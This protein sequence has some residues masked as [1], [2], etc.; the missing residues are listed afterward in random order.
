MKSGDVCWWLTIRQHL[1][2]WSQRIKICV[3]H[4]S[5][6]RH[7]LRHVILK[8]TSLITAHRA[9]FPTNIQPEGQHKFAIPGIVDCNYLTRYRM[10]VTGKMR[11]CG[12]RKVKCGIENAEAHLMAKASNHMTA[13]IPHITSIYCNDIRTVFDST[14]YFPH[15]AIP[16]LPI[17]QDDIYCNCKNTTPVFFWLMTNSPSLA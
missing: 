15:S 9:T 8:T 7:S 12:M 5:F 13:V 6:S 3:F 2:C 11:N 16:H 17:T 10:T 4:C 14:F 1:H